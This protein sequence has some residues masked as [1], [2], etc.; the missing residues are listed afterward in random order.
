M[1]NFIKRKKIYFLMV[2]F[3]IGIN[4]LKNI[5]LEEEIKKRLE[6]NYLQQ[7]KSISCN[8]ILNISCDLKNLIFEHNITNTNY[9]IDITNIKL[10]DLNILEGN[11]IEKNFKLNIDKIKIS[12]SRDAFVVLRE[13]KDLNLTFSTFNN[14]QILKINS[15]EKDLKVTVMVTWK[16]KEISLLKMKIDKSNNVIKQIIYELYKLKILEIIES[17]DENFSSTR[18]MNIPLGVD[19]KEVIS[20]KIFFGEPYTATSI[21]LV[22]EVE[23][24]DIVLEHNQDENISNFLRDILNNNGVSRLSIKRKKDEQ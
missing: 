24:L 7:M 14:S 19:T 2:L 21:L 1:I 4:L 3:L 12:D 6:K 10:F 13:P 16:N 9:H 5:Y 8:G 11:K 17:D 23:V 22:S 18:G 15:I 20:K